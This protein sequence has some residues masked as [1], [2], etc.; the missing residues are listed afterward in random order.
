MQ[1]PPLLQR[2][3]ALA[4]AHQP[5]QHERLRFAQIPARGADQIVPQ[6]AQRPHPLVAIHQ[7]EALGP[8]A[9]HD[10][11][12]DLLADRRQRPHQL[13]FRLG[14]VRPQL[15]VAQVQLVQLDVHAV[16]LVT[17]RPAVPCGRPRAAPRQP[18]PA[19]APR[20]PGRPPLRRRR[21]D[22]PA[23]KVTARR[24]TV[25]WL[26]KAGDPERARASHRRVSAA[27][28]RSAAR[29]G[30]PMRHLFRRLS[31]REV[32]LLAALVVGSPELRCA[33]S[34]R[35]RASAAR[36]GRPARTLGSRCCPDHRGDRCARPPCT[37]RTRTPAPRLPPPSWRPEGFTPPAI[38][39]T[40]DLAHRGSRHRCGDQEARDLTP[41]LH[42]LRTL[43]RLPQLGPFRQP[44]RVTSGGSL[45]TSTPLAFFA[46]V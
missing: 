1:Q 33:G 15:L 40:L 46:S 30:T 14:L 41:G 20:S 24:P 42:P 38:R 17:S 18:R 31:A 37:A 45:L 4:R 34:A 13:A 36:A 6:P 12:R 5:I 19:P 28:V 32:L 27:S 25:A 10:H 3:R 22:R 21:A 2:R 39:A 8:V 26:R 9:V 16:V 29:S 7:D 35:R 23:A 44:L 11:D 43:L